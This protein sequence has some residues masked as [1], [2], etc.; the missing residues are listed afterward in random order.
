MSIVGQVRQRPVYLC[1]A[2]MCDLSI[3]WPIMSKHCTSSDYAFEDETDSVRSEAV[4]WTAERFQLLSATYN[5]A[6]AQ[7]QHN[8]D[9]PVDEKYTKW[10]SAI[11]QARRPRQE[12]QGPHDLGKIPFQQPAQ[13]KFEHVFANLSG[14]AF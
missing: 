11:R 9:S 8:Q 4:M 1:C 3:E 13:D 12:V 6:V 5:R 2:I 7:V 10:P 14:Q